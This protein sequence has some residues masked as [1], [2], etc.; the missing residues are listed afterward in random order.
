MIVNGYFSNQYQDR[1][2]ALPRLLIILWPSTGGN[3]RS[4]RIKESELIEQ[5][6]TL[7]RYNPTSHGNS[8]GNYDPAESKEQ[9]IQFLRSNQLLEIPVIGVGHSGGGAALVMLEDQL[10]FVKRYLLSPIL[11]SRLSLEYLYQNQNIAEFLELLISDSLLDPSQNFNQREIIYSTL[12]DPTWM[13][14]G[15][16]NGLQFPVWNRRIHLADLATFLRNLFLPGFDITEP[17]L[18]SKSPIEIFLPREDKWFPKEKTLELGRKSKI[19]ITEIESAKDHFFTSSWL[20]VWEK[21]RSEI[22]T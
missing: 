17:I 4:F 19:T 20:S 18:N 6:I 21:I 2:L 22:Y 7:L 14:T 9:L 3:A 15:E 12:A 5:K 13:Q 10:N 16:I 1:S 8:F 11:N